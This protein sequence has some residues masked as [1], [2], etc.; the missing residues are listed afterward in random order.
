[1]LVQLDSDTLFLGDLRPPCFGSTVDDARARATHDG[2][3]VA[4]R[5][6]SGLFARAEELSGAASTPTF[7]LT[8]AA[9]AERRG[10]HG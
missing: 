8:R 6:S 5:R 9:R 10:G 1:M 7:A 4:A 3:F 2:G